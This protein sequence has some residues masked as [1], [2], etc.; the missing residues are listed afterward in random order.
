MWNRFFESV[1]KQLMRKFIQEANH[2]LMQAEA[3]EEWA[4]SGLVEQNIRDW[5]LLM[6]HLHK[7]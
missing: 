5:L 3:Q 2:L 6:P 1:H 7:N 4:T